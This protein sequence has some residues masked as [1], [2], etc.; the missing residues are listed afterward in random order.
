MKKYLIV[1][2]NKASAYKMLYTLTNTQQDVERFGY[3]EE[4]DVRYFPLWEGWTGHGFRV[5]GMYVDSKINQ[6]YFLECLVPMLKKE[7]FVKWF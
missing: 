7:N 1:G 4:N 5:D 6:A 2:Y 3:I